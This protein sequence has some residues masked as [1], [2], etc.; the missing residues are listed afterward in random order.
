[1]PFDHRLPSDVSLRARSPL[2]ERDPTL[3]VPLARPAPAAGEPA[4]RLV[5]IGGS[6]SQGFQNLAVSNTS[7]SWPKILADALGFPFR[8]PFFGGP[9]E[10]PGLPLNL[11][12]MLR[13]L[14]EAHGGRFLSLRPDALLTF[15]RLMTL[16]DRYWDDGDGFHPP[17]QPEFN[18]N[19]AI[20]GWD[21]RDALSKDRALLQK[22]ILDRPPRMH[23]YRPGVQDDGQIAALRVLAGPLDH[24]VTQLSA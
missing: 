4:H 6:L 5:V 23:F 16:V 10:C 14:E 12:A 9:C 24:E 21:L 19:L 1:M 17:V 20:Y 3:G 13:A 11:E 18:H 22:Q 2:P 7:L 8:V 15:T